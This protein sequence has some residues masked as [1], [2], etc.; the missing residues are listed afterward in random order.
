L[1]NLGGTAGSQDILDASG[2][3]TLTLKGSEL[4]TAGQIKNT[5]SS[6]QVLVLTDAYGG[7]FDN[8]AANGAFELDTIKEL[9]FGDFKVQLEAGAL[10]ELTTITGSGGA[11]SELEL[12]EE[13]SFDLTNETITGVTILDL[14]ETAADDITVNEVFIESLTTV[15]DGDSDDDNDLIIAATESGS[16]IDLTGV[17]F[18]DAIDE[19]TFDSGD[20]A[21]AVTLKINESGIQASMIGTNGG[22][23]ADDA[24]EIYASTATA[25][26][27]TGAYATATAIA[28]VGIFDG[29]GANTITISEAVGIRDITTVTLTA[30]ASDTIAISDLVHLATNA[31]GVNIK[32]FGAG[33]GADADVVD[34]L[35]ADTA[36]DL[37]RTADSDYNVV[38]SAA[39]ALTIN[40]TTS[41]Y[42]IVE[43]NQAVA[44]VTD[45]EDVAAGGTVEQA[46]GV[47]V[48]TVTTGAEAL[49]I[50]YGTGADSGKAGLYSVVFTAADAA[51]AN[52]TVELI[53][54][55]EG[56]AADALVSSNF[57]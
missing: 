9:Q 53:G 1:T 10:G 6:T 17:T 2:V 33:V 20:T 40:S 56:V 44:T 18:D 47:A 28:S 22:A 43:I 50:L 23:K 31:T 39:T 29:S 42:D 24:L 19:I 26:I 32:N 34:V 13:A 14:K 38:S 3:T 54:V 41:S 51:A 5:G 49:T 52:I 35:F 25:A 16:T 27:D 15:T 11:A 30:G 4:G 7:E 55:L 45:L 46:I 36:G 21:A 37:T 48:G 57:I 12:T 8:A